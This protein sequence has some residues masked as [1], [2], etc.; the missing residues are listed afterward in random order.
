MFV[1]KL[2]IWL[3]PVIYNFRNKQW[4]QDRA[5]V[6]EEGFDFLADFDFILLN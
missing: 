4:K 3:L 6:P 5:K 2:L 1:D